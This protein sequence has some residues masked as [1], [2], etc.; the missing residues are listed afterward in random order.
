MHLRCEETCH[1]RRLGKG[2]HIDL[3]NSGEWCV[4][5]TRGSIFLPCLPILESVLRTSYGYSLGR[6]W[7]LV[8]LRAESSFCENESWKFRWASHADCVGPERACRPTAL[9]GWNYTKKLLVVWRSRGQVIPNG[10]FSGGQATWP[11]SQYERYVVSSP[12]LVT[13]N[14]NSV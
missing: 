11:Q 10:E 9:D 1:K 5:E 4:L 12:Y 6:I 8:L 2:E 3:I 13:S 14:T 7:R